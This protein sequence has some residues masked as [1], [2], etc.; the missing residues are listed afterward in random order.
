MLMIN[1]ASFY[2]ILCFCFEKKNAYSWGFFHPFIFLL[3]V[4]GGN[5]REGTCSIYFPLV[6]WR[7]ISHFLRLPHAHAAGVFMGP[8]L[9]KISTEGGRFY[10][11]VDLILSNLYHSQKFRSVNLFYCSKVDFVAHSRITEG[12]SE[13]EVHLFFLSST[14]SERLVT[15]SF[16]YTCTC[17]NIQTRT[18]L[19]EIHEF[20][21]K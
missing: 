11:T 12:G 2:F 9:K 6:M 14:R 10:K 3:P 1:I 16:I 18:F 8:G 15:N 13:K 21:F 4:R 19:H 17:F 20:V 5:P 7:H